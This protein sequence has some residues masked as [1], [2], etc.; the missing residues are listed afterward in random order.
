MPLSTTKRWLQ[1]LRSDGDMASRNIGRPR[2]EED[3]LCALSLHV[4]SRISRIDDDDGDDDTWR[5]SVS[6][7]QQ[8]DNSSKGN[9]TTHDPAEVEFVHQPLHI[10]ST[11]SHSTLSLGKS[12]LHTPPLSL[13]IASRRQ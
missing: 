2:G 5:S 8:T 11:F 4:S 6:N 12:R 3:V 7:A 13:S 9:V 1:R 10:G